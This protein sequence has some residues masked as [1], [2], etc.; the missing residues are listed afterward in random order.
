VKHETKISLIVGVKRQ[1][2]QL[3]SDNHGATSCFNA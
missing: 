3:Q 2:M 1:G